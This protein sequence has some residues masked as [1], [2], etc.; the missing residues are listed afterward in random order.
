MTGLPEF[1]KQT[2]D[3]PYIRHDYKLI[4]NEGQFIVFDNYTD[5]QA[6]WFQTPKMFLSHIEVLDKQVK[7]KTKTRGFK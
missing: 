3:E 4:D 6:V 2:S 7:Q 5:T 1:F